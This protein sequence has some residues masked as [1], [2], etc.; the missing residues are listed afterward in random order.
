MVTPHCQQEDYGFRELLRLGELES[1]CLGL[2]K[3]D[4]HRGGC[5][6]FML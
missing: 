3:L 5:G 2:N 1:S 4:I 6:A